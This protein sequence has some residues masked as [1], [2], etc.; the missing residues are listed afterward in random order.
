VT[1]KVYCEKT[2]AISVKSFVF[3]SELK[4]TMDRENRYNGGFSGPYLR[5]DYPPVGGHA[6]N[7]ERAT[8]ISPA[9]VTKTITD[10]NGNTLVEQLFKIY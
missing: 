8:K 7:D 6:P 1:L 2:A 9:G 5:Y 4:F 10:G 3:S